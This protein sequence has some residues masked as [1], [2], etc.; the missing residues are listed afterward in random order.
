[1]CSSVED[2]V[3]GG[4]LT[5]ALVIQNSIE[6]QKHSSHKDYLKVPNSLS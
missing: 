5:E 2:W 1:M 4:G 3:G 6:I